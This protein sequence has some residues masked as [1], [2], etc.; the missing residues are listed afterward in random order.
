MFL[1][2]S[3][4]VAGHCTALTVCKNVQCD[5]YG[6]GKPHDRTN[7]HGPYCI[8][9]NPWCITYNCTV[10]TSARWC[11]H[12]EATRNKDLL[13]TPVDVAWVD[14]H[15][16][17]ER[18]SLDFHVLPL[19]LAMEVGVVDLRNSRGT[20]AVVYHEVPPLPCAISNLHHQVRREC[21]EEKQPVVGQSLSVRSP[22]QQPFL[23]EGHNVLCPVGAF[24]AV[25]HR[26]RERVACGRY[27]TTRRHQFARNNTLRNE[28]IPRLPSADPKACARYN[29]YLL[30]QALQ[31]C[32]TLKQVAWHALG[33]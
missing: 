6:L 12:Q 32:T 4:L 2:G 27:N 13:P 14:P 19:K 22:G 29:K 33:S 10:L 20:P 25:R 31:C 8:S 9:S 24:G 11:E 7:V 1:E 15:L 16:V 21:V 5:V 23:Q 3:V 18:H 17:E 30:A 28:A 26:P